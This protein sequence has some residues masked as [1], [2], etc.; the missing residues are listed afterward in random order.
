MAHRLCRPQRFRV[1]RVG[2]DLRFVTMKHIAPGKARV[3]WQ[4]PVLPQAVLVGPN[5]TRNTNIWPDLKALFE[6]YR[7]T[8][9]GLH[10]A[11]DAPWLDFNLDYSQGAMLLLPH[12]VEHEIHSHF[13]VQLRHSGFS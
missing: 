11:L 4:Q 12:V 3:A 13:P 2:E 1:A 10:A 6:Q 7:S 9:P 5:A 8:L